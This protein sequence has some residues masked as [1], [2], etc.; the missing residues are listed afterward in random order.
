VLLYQLMAAEAAAQ[1]GDLGAAHAIYLKLARETRDPR[2]AR[3]AAE[4]ALQGRALPQ[5]L[6]ASRL[7]HELAPGSTEA[8]QALAM[9]YAANA[10]FD[11][12]YP[13]FL[14]QLQASARPAED[15]LQIQRALAR[16]QDRAGAFALLENWPRPTPRSAE[17]RLVL[18]SGAHAA[19]MATACGR[20]SA[21]CS[22]AGA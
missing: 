2:L 21:R 13:L 20:R 5:A 22:Q 15:L 4:L 7:W 10:R 8:R 14:E 3:R 9:L 6:E 17:I 11:E 16:S 18:A 19:G 1:R 12:A